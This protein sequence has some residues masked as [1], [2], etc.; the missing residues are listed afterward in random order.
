MWVQYQSSITQGLKSISSSPQRT[1]YVRN[2]TKTCK[3]GCCMPQVTFYE[4]HYLSSSLPVLENKIVECKRMAASPFLAQSLWTIYE[5]HFY[6][7]ATSR[8]TPWWACGCPRGWWPLGSASPCILEPLFP[9]AW[10]SLRSMTITKPFSA[11]W[12][13]FLLA[14]SVMTFKSLFRL[15]IFWKW[16][17]KE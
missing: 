4:Q 9:C 17:E 5:W 8:P 10:S 6:P 14:H 3:M 2:C 12:N 11:P 16:T 13:L 7:P 15:P 1:T